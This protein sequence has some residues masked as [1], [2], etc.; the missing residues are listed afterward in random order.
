MVSLDF[1]ELPAR[2]DFLERAA[3]EYPMVI[4][5]PKEWAILAAAINQGIDAHLEAVATL[6]ADH[7]TGELVIADAGSLHT[8][9]RRLN[10]SGDETAED[11]ASVILHTLGYEWI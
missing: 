3:G 10:E 2:E 9:L 6:K 11:L 7:T 5:D 4:R 1:G 8:L